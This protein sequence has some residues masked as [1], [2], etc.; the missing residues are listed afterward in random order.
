MM[1][2]A[3]IVPWLVSIVLVEAALIDGLKLRVPNW[4]TFHLVLG[5]LCYAVWASG[6]QGLLWS[7]EG[8][9]LAWACSCRCTRSAGWGRAT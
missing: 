9:A 3:P 2:I 4:L 6:V 8:A 7:L 1:P 5:G